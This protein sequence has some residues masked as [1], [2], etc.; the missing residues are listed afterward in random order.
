MPTNPNSCPRNGN[1]AKTIVAELNPMID[2]K[3]TDP[4]DAHPTPNKLVATPAKDTPQSFWIFIDW[5]K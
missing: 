1:I 2:V 3:T 5:R 4:Q